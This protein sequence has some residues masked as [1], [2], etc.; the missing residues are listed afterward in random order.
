MILNLI[1][2]AETVSIMRRF[3]VKSY[4]HYTFLDNYNTKFN[5]FISI[6]LIKHNRFEGFNTAYVIQ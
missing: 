5:T 4:F 2:K 3:F 6:T 1:F